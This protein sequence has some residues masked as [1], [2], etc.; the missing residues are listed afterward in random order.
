MS[1]KNPSK[2]KK[3]PKKAVKPKNLEVAACVGEGYKIESVEQNVLDIV[4]MIIAKGQKLVN[5]HAV[6][7]RA[8]AKLAQDTVLF[9]VDTAE[10]SDTLCAWKRGYTV[11]TRTLTLIIIKML[12]TWLR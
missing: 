4:R 11:F 1:G 6:T 2:A 12:M 9:A 8:L 7:S 10:V 5:E 3:V